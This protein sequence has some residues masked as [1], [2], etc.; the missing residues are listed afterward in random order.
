VYSHF[1]VLVPRVFDPDER[2]RNQVS[3]ICSSIPDWGL[4]RWFLSGENRCVDVKV[5]EDMYQA[6]AGFISSL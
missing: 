6:H 4:R 1:A 2:P 3:R 5:T